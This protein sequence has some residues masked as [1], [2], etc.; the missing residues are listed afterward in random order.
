MEII[1]FSKCTVEQSLKRYLFSTWQSLDSSKGPTIIMGL[2]E[3]DARTYYGGRSDQWKFSSLE[4]ANNS[5]SFL[6]KHSKWDLSNPPEQKPQARYHSLD[7]KQYRK[8]FY[9]ELDITG[10]LHQL[11]TK[12]NTGHPVR[13]SLHVTYEHRSGVSQFHRKLE[14]FSGASV[15]MLFPREKIST[16]ETSSLHGSSSERFFGNSG[17]LET[18]GSSEQSAHNPRISSIS[19]KPKPLL[20]AEGRRIRK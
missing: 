13:S 14:L 8:I 3:F 20:S 15:K 17:R 9:Q 2:A 19:H 10:L 11:S 7:R 6:G 1:Q 4:S 18:L 12:I 5:T 16:K